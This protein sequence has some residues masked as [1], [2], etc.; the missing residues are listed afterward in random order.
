MVRDICPRRFPVTNRLQGRGTGK[1]VCRPTLVAGIT[2]FHLRKKRGKLLSEAPSTDDL[3]A[4]KLAGYS[5][6]DFLTQGLIG[7][8]SLMDPRP[9]A[10]EERSILEHFSTDKIQCRGSHDEG[11]SRRGP[12]PLNLKAHGQLKLPIDRGYQG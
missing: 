8:V 7:G 12:I 3:H 2:S 9:L 6:S 11:F 5:S 1:I 10:P 4:N